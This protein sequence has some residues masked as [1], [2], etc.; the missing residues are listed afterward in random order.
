ME[1]ESQSDVSDAPIT[2]TETNP[3]SAMSSGKVVKRTNALDVL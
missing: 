1:E 2:E 3:D